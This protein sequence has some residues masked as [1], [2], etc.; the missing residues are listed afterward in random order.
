VWGVISAEP[1]YPY[2]RHLRSLA[3]LGLSDDQLARLAVADAQG[4][5]RSLG[6]LGLQPT[7]ELRQRAAGD[8]GRVAAYVARY[9]TSRA[10]DVA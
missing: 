10:A 2:G 4:A 5:I 8:P 3:D 7:D 9:S 6:A 1:T